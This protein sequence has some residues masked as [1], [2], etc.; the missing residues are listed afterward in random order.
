MMASYL[1]GDFGTFFLGFVGV[2]LEIMAL[3]VTSWLRT[4]DCADKLKVRIHHIALLCGTLGKSQA[5]KK[6]RIRISKQKNMYITSKTIEHFQLKMGRGRYFSR[7]AQYYPN[8][9][10]L[11]RVWSVWDS[12]PHIQQPHLEPYK[13][14][15]SKKLQ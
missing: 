15:V 2:F 10:L 3:K 9:S 6:T 11:V 7:L 13:K 5:I 8:E 1:F 14:R 4:P 12:N